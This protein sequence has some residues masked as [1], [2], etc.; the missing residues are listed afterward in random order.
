MPSIMGR[1][2]LSI[3]RQGYSS[4]RRTIMLKRPFLF[5]FM[6]VTAVASPLAEAETIVVSNTQDLFRPD[7]TN[8]CSLREAVYKANLNP[9]A[10]RIE[11]RPGTYTL[12][13][14]DPNWNPDEPDPDEDL[15]V[16]GDLDISGGLT[17]I[18]DKDYNTIIQG[19]SDRLIEVLPD[20][21]EFHLR[22]LSLRGG[23]ADDY[24]GAI[25]NNGISV[26]A[27]VGF[28]D[29]HVTPG[30]ASKGGAIANLDT[31]LISFSLFQGNSANGDQGFPGLGGAIYNRS[32]M[33]IR[34]SHFEGNS[35]TDNATNL[36]YGG[37]VYNEFWV[38]VARSSFVG[39]YA[40]G[41]GAAVANDGNWLSLFRLV[42]GTVS[43]N[44]GVGAS[45]S[46]ANG[47]PEVVSSGSSKME[48]SH[49]TLVGNQGLGLS[50][51]GNLSVRNS[52]V[53]GN[54]L[55]QAP[56]N[57]SH[58]G[59]GYSA[60]GLALGADQGECVPTSWVDE[61]ALFTSVLEPSLRSTGSEPGVGIGTQYH[62]IMAGSPILDSAVGSCT[63]HDQRSAPRPVDG[64]H[65]GQ[66]VCDIGAYERQN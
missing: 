15:G 38:D 22:H 13:L 10:D 23:R 56:A 52:I 64:D 62:E 20:G 3:L 30:V 61:T 32:L 1:R 39:N 44:V 34:D 33:R 43:G 47:L 14:S 66:A 50:N 24:G 31:M 65:D 4:I 36:A 53:A 18:G 28:Y 35:A 29:N 25:L 5:P 42:N 37:A 48:L 40:E 57:C 6:L 41:G 16:R 51:L 19:R 63:S 7:C 11:L 17:L 58:Q 59:T 12:S 2:K 54:T 60:R 46:L 49:V 26:I 45:G 27:F 21:G 55:N 9:G 8:D